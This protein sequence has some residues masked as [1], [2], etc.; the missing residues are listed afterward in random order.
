MKLMSLRRNE[1][2]ITM[3]DAFIVLAPIALTVGTVLWSVR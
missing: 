3:R 1:V 2:F